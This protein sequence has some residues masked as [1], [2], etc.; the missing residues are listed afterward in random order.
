VAEGEWSHEVGRA[1]RALTRVQLEV[2]VRARVA[3]AGRANAPDL[4]TA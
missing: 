2:Q 3:D 1:M 4:I